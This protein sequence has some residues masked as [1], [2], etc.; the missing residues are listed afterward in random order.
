[1]EDLPN[2]IINLNGDDYVLTPD[3]YYFKLRSYGY[4]SC[5]LGLM[6]VDLPIEYI[7]LGDIFLKNYYTHFDV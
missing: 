2:L 7:I 4:T 1:L 5:I 3:D 6:S